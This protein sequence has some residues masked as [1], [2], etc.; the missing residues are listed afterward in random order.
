MHGD[1]FAAFI[2]EATSMS[3]EVV[4]RR[5]FDNDVGEY[6]AAKNLTEDF[7]TWLEA[8]RAPKKA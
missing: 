3:N 1:T 6:L 8:K 5:D 7:N 4:A 2:R